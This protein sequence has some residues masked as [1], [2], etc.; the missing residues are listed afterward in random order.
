MFFG[1]KFSGAIDRWGHDD[2]GGEK[3]S[4]AAR[5]QSGGGGKAGSHRTVFAQY[6][7]LTPEQKRAAAK[8][9]RLAKKGLLPKPARK[10]TESR[11]LSSLI[12]IHF[13]VSQLIQEN[14]PG[15][16]DFKMQFECRWNCLAKIRL[17]DPSK[18]SPHS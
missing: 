15:H 17:V 10:E 12:K 11:V 5:G 16:I 14:D 7:Q 2:S 6:E 8:K 4:G 3:P 18:N 9:R 13:A 1:G